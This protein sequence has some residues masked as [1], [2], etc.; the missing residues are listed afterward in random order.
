MKS[1]GGLIN[2]TKSQIYAGIQVQ[3]LWKLLL[4][5]YNFH[6]WTSGKL[7]NIWEFLFVLFLEGEASWVRWHPNGLDL[8][9]FHDLVGSS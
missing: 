2:A 4:E 8:T 5:S 9:R 3:E 6:L 1:S 7:S